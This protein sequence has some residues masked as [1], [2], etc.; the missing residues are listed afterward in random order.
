MD[1]YKK[2]LVMAKRRR[3]VMAGPWKPPRSDN[4][5]YRKATPSDL[6]ENRER[7]IELG[8][9]YKGEIQRSLGTEDKREAERRYPSVSQEVE[10]MWEGWREALRE[11]P[12]ALSY[13]QITALAGLIG[14][15]LLSEYEANPQMTPRPPHDWFEFLFATIRGFG[16]IPRIYMGDPLADFKMELEAIPAAKLK[17]HLSSEIPKASAW[18]KSWLTAS[19]IVLSAYFDTVGRKRSV[20]LLETL[21]FVPDAN[22]VLE[23]QLGAKHFVR[24]AY[25]SLGDRLDRRYS[26]PEWVRELPTFERDS[27]ERVSSSDATLRAITLSS[28]IDEQEEASR[29]EA[30]TRPVTPA[31]I[32]KYRTQCKQLAE[33]RGRDT[34]YDILGE[35]V[36]R[37]KRHL[38]E[39]G[40]KKK[41]VSSK[42]GTIKSVIKWGI[43]Q[44]QGRLF[45]N[46]FPLEYVQLPPKDAPSVAG[47]AYNLDQAKRVLEYSRSETKAHLRWVPW[48]LAYT[49]MRVGEA[50]QLEQGDFF[51]DNNDWFLHIRV[52]EGRTT[53]TKKERMVPIHNDLVKE[54][55]IGYYETVEQ[56]RMFTGGSLQQRQGEWIKN[57]VFANQE[58]RPAP[59]HGFRHFWE[60]RAVGH[61]EHRAALY[62]TGRSS[63]SSLDDYLNG[64]S[65]YPALAREMAK[66][67]SV[68]D[69]MR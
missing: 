31:T 20:K 59:N 8:V 17:S 63:Q 64:E 19:L 34:A 35:E 28:I 54:G 57:K 48:L 30:I 18:R 26:E 66:L 5:Y 9:S 7:L 40:D 3:W 56:G 33:F 36:E 52:G 38:L 68:L 21:N 67:P 12:V 13:Q 39:K 46:G 22:T 45:P 41:T 61:V 6:S 62:I 49:G 1:Y 47:K 50:L 27:I 55:L 24:M 11:G 2:V 53:K 65:M 42:I 58:E 51:Q 10:S 37:W 60:T 25:E 4:W 23:L 69:N 16:V 43:L 29:I 32:R 15:S 44:T 14:E